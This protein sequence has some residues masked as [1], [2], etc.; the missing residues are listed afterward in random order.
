MWR[1]AYAVLLCVRFYFALCPSYIHPDEN[2]QGP[3][4]I[5]GTCDRAA[6][7]LRS[8]TASLGSIFDFPSRRTW[9]WTSDTPIRS[10]FPLWPAYGLPM[11]LLQWV[12]P[13]GPDESINPSVVYYTLRSVM[14]ILSFVLEDW[15]IHELVRSPRYRRQAAVLVTSS[16]VTWTYQTHTFSNSVET[17]IVLWSLV[18]IERIAKEEVSPMEQI[19]AACADIS[20]MLRSPQALS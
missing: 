7:Y 16:Y 15:A 8:L 3:E 13:R 11:T 10:V 1:R 18:L 2:F 5:A 4:V 20:R 17:I 9:E 12:W 19:S 14:F 6:T